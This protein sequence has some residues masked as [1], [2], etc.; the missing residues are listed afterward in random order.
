M[1][2][3]KTATLPP[4]TRRQT[5]LP[6]SN[7]ASRRII[8]LRASTVAA[9]ATWVTCG[10]VPKDDPQRLRQ[11]V[12]IVDQLSLSLRWPSSAAMSLLCPRPSPAL[13]GA[14]DFKSASKGQAENV[15][16]R[17]NAPRR[18]YRCSTS[19]AGIVPG[20]DFVVLPPGGNSLFF[21]LSI[22]SLSSPRE[23]Q[24]W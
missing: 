3:G 19:A 9:G 13:F 20:N 17:F 2:S 8:D 6:Q 22:K 1:Y 21:P 10:Q 7:T 4:S 5:R 11:V 14:L 24:G 12:G 16:H 15:A 23:S 18:S